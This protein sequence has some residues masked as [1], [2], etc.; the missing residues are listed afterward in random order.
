[1]SAPAQDNRPPASIQAP[2]DG[3]A[4]LPP[5]DMT[6]EGPGSLL[7]V[8]PLA[9]SVDFDQLN[10]VGVRVVYRSTNANGTAT[11]V[12]GVVAVPP[13][14]QPSGGWPIL[15]FGHDITG[16]LEDCAPSTFQGLGGYSSIVSLLAGRGYVVVMTDYEGLGVDGFTHPLLDSTTLGHNMIDGVRAA[17]HVLPSASNRWAAFGLGQGGAATWAADAQAASYGTGLD[18]VGAVAV[19]PLAN[20][21]GLADAMENETLAPA[22]FRLAMLTLTSLV[23]SPDKRL[24]P[25][26]Y[27]SENAKERFGDLTN[28]AV[29]DPVKAVAAAAGLHPSDFKPRTPA[30]AENL[31]RDLQDLALP[32]TSSLSA[33]MFVIYATIDPVVL[34]DWI[35]QAVRTACAR[36]DPIEVRKMLDASVLNDIV[37]YDSVGWIQGRFGGQHP[38]DVC[39]GV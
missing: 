18:L 39:V 21:T 11:T 17:R 36:G 12:S 16:M 34:P 24:N 9:D 33:P 38:T 14:K 5:A 6:D 37:L 27:V 13:G 25:D 31:R 7:D 8:Q 15:A 35:E 26:D 2:F 32:G 29:V 23:L 19:S 22:Q 30:A 4:V 10:V 20:M 28:C 3:A 1:V